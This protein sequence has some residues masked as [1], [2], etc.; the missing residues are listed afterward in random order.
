VAGKDAYHINISI[1]LDMINGKI[2]S[3][4]PS[5]VSG[6]KIDSA[7][8]DLW[9]Y[10]E[11]NLLAKAEAKAASSTVGNLDVIVTVTDY[12]KPVTI[13]APPANQIAP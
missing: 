5:A 6:I 7:S 12:D 13:S 1:P 3:A 4:A 8:V 10:K 2:A 9:V 11:N